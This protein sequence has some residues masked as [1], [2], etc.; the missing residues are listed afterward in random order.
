MAIEK[1]NSGVVISSSRAVA[2]SNNA[3]GTFKPA[4]HA[5]QRKPVNNKQ[6]GNVQASGS[7]GEMP[8]V[9]PFQ[10][11][12]DNG[13][14]IQRKVLIGGSPA[15]DLGGGKAMMGSN[16]V[17][18]PGDRMSWV[19]D[20]YARRYNS[21]EEFMKHAGGEE[22]GFGLAKKL[23]KWYRLTPLENKRF[24]VLGEYHNGFGYRE[25]MNES[26]QKGKVLGE[27]GSNTL[28]TATPTSALEKN[29]TKSA[30]KNE[31]NEVRE[32]TMENAV[33]KAYYGLTSFR[34]TEKAKSKPKGVDNTEKEAGDTWLENYQNAAKGNRDKDAGHI[35]YYKKGM[36]KVYAE[37]GTAAEKYDVGKT[38]L[39]VLEV[40][41]KA[42][43]S[44][45]TRN[46]YEID[47]WLPTQYFIREYKGPWNDKAEEEYDKLIAALD[48]GAIAETNKLA[49]STGDHVAPF[50]AKVQERTKRTG[51]SP[52]ASE[53][54]FAHR[55]IAMYNSVI[56][57]STQG[58]VMA[59]MGDFHARDL[60]EPLTTA[61]I[62]VITLNE[63]LG[64]PISTDA[65]AP[66]TEQD[67]K[68][69]EKEGAMAEAKGKYLEEQEKFK[70]EQEDA[71]PVETPVAET[72][73]L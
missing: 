40:F 42:I 8:A 4:V 27:G 3:T 1:R 50:L 7:E 65:I 67:D 70:K 55:N 31:R 48:K 63:F 37:H 25:L 72:V 39:S 33:S 22:V 36:K 28:M 30:L 54:A 18:V 13:G 20:R 49:G 2:H 9:S 29:R 58:F 41:W 51:I 62:T 21:T 34:L 45:T 60:K 66:M 44:K 35:P 6:E 47:A 12:P 5:F 43:D 69:A 71:V 14:I 23:G 73:G 10:L 26:N 57:A 24:F 19:N 68:F 32:Y 17:T 15:I 46:G 53:K 59:G 16:V 52:W 11:K 38:G 56:K 64:A 61:G